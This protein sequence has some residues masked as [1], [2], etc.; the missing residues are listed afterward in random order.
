MGKE[1]G[2]LADAEA[3]H[4]FKL[5]L[6]S[7]VVSRLDVQRR[8]FLPLNTVEFQNRAQRDFAHTLLYGELLF[9]ALS[10]LVLQCAKL[11]DQLNARALL[12]GGSERRESSPAV[13]TN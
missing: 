7:R 8:F 11:P 2:L 13:L 12:Q 1:I 4:G 10:V 6:D 5:E 9:V 3:R